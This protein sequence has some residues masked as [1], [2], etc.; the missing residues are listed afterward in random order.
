DAVV[1]LERDDVHLIM[2]GEGDAEADLR[3]RARPLGTRAHFLPT[4]GRDIASVC[5]AFDVSL[6]C[7]SPTEGAPLA[8]IHS[9]FASRP[10]LATADE[11][12]AGLI[13]PGAGAIVSP[14]HDPA[15]LMD[16]LKAYLDDENRR[17][18]EG[19]AARAIADRLFAAPIVAERIEQLIRR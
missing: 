8:V 6:F 18:R 14:E 7:P 11:G 12:V 3:G 17:E 2:A 5:S 19:S 4:P 15:A 16:V 1:M 10:C 13:V 9:M